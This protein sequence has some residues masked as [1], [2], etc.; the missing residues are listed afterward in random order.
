LAELPSPAGHTLVHYT[1]AATKD[2][3]TYS[4]TIVGR[5]ATGLDQTTTTIE[6]LVVPLRIAP[7]NQL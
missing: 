3:R 5:S 1:I 2:G 4:G 6:V 7:P